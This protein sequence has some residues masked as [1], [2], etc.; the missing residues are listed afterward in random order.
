MKACPLKKSGVIHSGTVTRNKKQ[1]LHI[2]VWKDIFI[3]FNGSA[4]IQTYLFV[5]VNWHAASYEWRCSQLGN[6]FRSVFTF[7]RRMK[8]VMSKVKVKWT[9]VQALRL[10]TG[11]TAYRGSRGIVLLFLDHGTRRR[12]RSASRRG[13]SLPPGKSRYSLYRRLG[14]PQ[15]SSGQVRKFSPPPGFDPR[16]IQRVASRYTDWATRSTRNV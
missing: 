13:R 3:S 7:P 12:E 1:N 10:C 8:Y 2:C 4:S 9:L 14:G 6:V 11:R 5:T 16:T 15:G